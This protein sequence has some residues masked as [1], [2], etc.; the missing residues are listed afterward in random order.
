M[1]KNPFRRPTELI[2]FPNQVLVLAKPDA[3]H[4]G[5]VGMIITM[6]EFHGFW[7]RDTRELQMT[8]AFCAKHYCDHIDKPFY[9][10][11][12]EFM[13]SGLTIAFRMECTRQH[14]GMMIEKARDRVHR[15]RESRQ[16]V[17]PQNLLH[18]S[19]SLDAARRELNLWFPNSRN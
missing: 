3:V 11:L 5:Q 18:A 19:D 2:D 17:G 8:R 7:I 15:I 12:V 9:K 4:N 14:D 1:F 16:C 10:S 6:F 13:I